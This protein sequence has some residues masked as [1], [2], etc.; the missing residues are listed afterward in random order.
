MEQLPDLPPTTRLSPLVLRILGGNPSKFT[1]QGT[2][3]YLIGSGPKR[4]LLDTGEGK[5]VF[6]SS[7]RQALKDENATIEKVLL[8]HWHPDH[9]GGVSDVLALPGCEGA[10]V[11]KHQPTARQEAVADGEVI[12][13]EPPPGQIEID[14]G[15]VIRT[16][17]ATLRALHC[18]GH[19]VDHMAFIL[20]EEDAMFTGDNVLGHGTAVFEDLGA[21]MSSLELM[22]KQFAGRAYPGHGDVISDGKG[23]VGEYIRHR[24]QR[25]GEV[26]DVLG[27][28]REDGHEGW[29]SME[30]VKVVYR[31]YPEHLHGP[32]E[33]GVV[34]VLRKL[35]G[36]GGGG[37]VVFDGEGGAVK[38]LDMRNCMK[39]A[40]CT[41]S[42]N[43]ADA[44]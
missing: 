15:Q 28:K 43:Y 38:I 33:G 24:R 40:I 32:A 44:R 21:Y 5:P 27:T 37:E 41:Y 6:A 19:T 3:C 8:S 7:L 23:K 25:E 12:A 20:Q 31:Q 14:D 18:P 22:E 13:Y 42:T 26:V 29:T 1:L 34:Q 39:D 2:N 30:I 36:E 4:I 17:G 9:V 11:L 10:E 16:E 35:E